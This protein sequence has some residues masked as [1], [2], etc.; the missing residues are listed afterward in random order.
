MGVQE[1]LTMHGACACMKR[2][3]DCQLLSFFL[4][5]FL[6]RQPV[7]GLTRERQEQCQPI[8][9][10]WTWRI[11]CLTRPAAVCTRQSSLAAREADSPCA[12]GRLHSSHQPSV[13]QVPARIRHREREA[14]RT[15]SILASS[16]LSR[17]GEY[18]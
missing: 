9:S 5:Y 3:E 17:R 16:P 10:V 13:C 2:V 8:H 1:A 4:Y 7:V 6:C 15:M 12:Q 18:R 14:E 11:R